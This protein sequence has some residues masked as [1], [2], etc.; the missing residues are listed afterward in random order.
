LF[1]SRGNQ[2]VAKCVALQGRKERKV[3]L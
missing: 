2:N 1:F 3:D